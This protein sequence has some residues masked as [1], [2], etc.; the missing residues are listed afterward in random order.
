MSTLY[1]GYLLDILKS[2]MS[3]Y[4]ECCTGF[5]AMST[6]AWISE[7]GEGELFCTYN[8]SALAIWMT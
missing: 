1:I 7:E 3:L 5:C 6:P 2:T 8:L 4:H